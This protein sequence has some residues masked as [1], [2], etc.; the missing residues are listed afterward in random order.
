MFD[1]EVVG[2]EVEF[3]RAKEIATFTEFFD[4]EEEAYNFITKN[5][6]NWDYFNLTKTLQ[7]IIF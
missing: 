6:H 4:T 2:Y 7:A 3:S 1:Y 5:R